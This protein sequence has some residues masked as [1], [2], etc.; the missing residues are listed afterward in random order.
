MQT[1]IKIL[2]DIA[3]VGASLLGLAF[4]VKTE[5]QQKLKAKGENLARDMNLVTRDEFEVV[6]S[7][8]QKA[9]EENEVLKE[10]IDKLSIKKK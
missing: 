4:G 7:M 9:R 5:L 6:R 2:D 3:K 8:A 10:Q 1:T